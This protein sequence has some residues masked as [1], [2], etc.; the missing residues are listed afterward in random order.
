MKV[1]DI[2]QKI[3]KGEEVP[4][5]K[6][7]TIEYFVNANGF[8]TDQWGEIVEWNIYS[9]WLDEEVE[10]LEDTPKKI[11]KLHIEYEP[12]FEKHCEKISA[13]PD[14]KSVA[15]KINEIIDYIN[16]GNNE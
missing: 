8:L 14:E 9:E 11:E 4:H 7:D 16:R 6:I 5:F 3:A 12:D 1:I 2:L 15:L 10:L 13:I